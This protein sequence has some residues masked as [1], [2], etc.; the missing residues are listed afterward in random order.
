MGAIMISLEFRDSVFE[1]M[2]D[3]FNISCQDLIYCYHND[4]RT[5]FR[6][7]YEDSFT[8]GYLGMDVE[9]NRLFLEPN[10][11]KKFSVY[12]QADDYDAFSKNFKK[13]I[14]LEPFL[15]SVQKMNNSPILPECTSI[16]VSSLMDPRSP[17]KYKLF[18]GTTYLIDEIVQIRSIEL[19]YNQYNVYYYNPRSSGAVIAKISIIDKDNLIITV[20][21]PKKHIN[22]ISK[23]FQ[24]KLADIEEVNVFFTKLLYLFVLNIDY[25]DISIL[26]G[27]DINDK[28]ILYSILKMVSI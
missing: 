12:A 6:L 25:T 26:D 14:F 13:C 17:F 15:S 4:N 16:S 27:I 23:E 11:I 8:T 9:F 28:E 21:P 10:E 24:F 2:R 3:S 18:S 22:Q 5:H 7:A 1:V 19:D 20:N